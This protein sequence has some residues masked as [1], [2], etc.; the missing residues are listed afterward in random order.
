MEISICLGFFILGTFLGSFF[1]VV[2]SRL[3]NGESIVYPRSHCPYCNHYLEPWELIPIFSYLLQKGRCTKCKT[4]I[5]IFYPISEILAGLLFLICYLVFGLS[6]DLIIALTLVSMIIIVTLSDY[7]YM[8]I[9]D[10]VLI[11]TTILLLI[12]IYYINGSDILLSSLIS[13]LI[14]FI[15][16]LLLK[17][18]GDFLFKKESMGGGDIKLMFIFGL[19]IGWKMSILSIFMAAFIALPYSLFILK[20]HKEHILPFGPFLCAAV[21]IIYF[22]QINFDMVINLLTLY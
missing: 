1:N 6:Y 2:A 9:N 12:E 7:Y 13:G 11:I 15:I 16:M 21:L 18:F 22:L 8:I 3:P 17:L 10:S 19:I 14:S 20:K 5:S 4:K